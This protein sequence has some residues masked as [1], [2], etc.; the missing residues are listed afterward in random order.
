MPRRFNPRG[1][2]YTTYLKNTG[3]M[4][5]QE[6]EETELNN[7]EQK[8]RILRRRHIWKLVLHKCD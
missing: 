6:I 3:Q 8:A 4:P 7:D 2:A 1:R 5:Y